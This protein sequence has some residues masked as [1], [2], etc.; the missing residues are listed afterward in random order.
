MASSSRKV[1][2][3]K[4]LG[5]VLCI[6]FL[7]FFT[8][9]CSGVK[10]VE[11]R[12]AKAEVVVS[13]E[14][15]AQV[16]PA[17]KEEPEEDFDDRKPEETVEDNSEE[18]SEDEIQYV[19]TE[20]YGLPKRYEQYFTDTQDMHLESAQNNGI[21]PFKS[22]AEID[23]RV[24]ALIASCKL[25]KIEANTKYSVDDLTISHP[26][27]VP[28][29][30]KFLDDLATEFQNITESKSRFCVSSGLRT[31]EDIRKLQG[32]NSNATTKS[33]H[34][35][36]TTID[37]AYARYEIDPDRPIRMP[38]LRIALAG[39]LRDMQKEGRCLVKFERKQ[40]CYHITIK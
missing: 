33:A 2:L 37:I 29:C 1:F 10:S 31:E 19:E 35:Y 15:K 14:N 36:G 21:T 7:G 4:L 24:P 6:F 26:Y 25:K 16:S 13:D 34:L 18:I 12:A 32:R 8:G 38:E 3:S 11:R 23:E 20:F 28:K 40:Y 27:V 9:R 5:A 39:V 17:E 30:A 22:R